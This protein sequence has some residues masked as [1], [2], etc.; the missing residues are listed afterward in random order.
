M[1]HLPAIFVLVLASCDAS[2][3]RSSQLEGEPSH[4]MAQS[5]AAVERMPEGESPAEIGPATTLQNE[6]SL[7]LNVANLPSKRVRLSGTTNLPSGTKLSLSVEEV[8]ENGFFGQSTCFV[9]SN[10]DFESEA[11]GPEGGLKDGRYVANATMP[12][13]SVQPTAV[14]KVIGNHG[15]NLTGSLVKKGSL[16]IIVSQQKEFAIGAMPEA[17]QAERKHRSDA[18][19][20]ALKRNLCVYLEQLLAFKNDRAFREY[21]FGIGGPYNKWL[22]G[23]E[24]LRAAQP[25]GSHSIPLVL[26]AA[27]GDLVTLGMDFMRKGETDYTRQ[28]LP[29]LKEAIGFDAYLAAKNTSLTTHEM[30][31]GTTPSTGASSTIAPANPISEEP[32]SAKERRERAEAKLNF[33]KKLLRTNVNAAKKRLEEIVKDFADTEAATEA[34][35]LLEVK[36]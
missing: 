25:K 35:K 32:Q 17:A 2:T 15:E 27:P 6:V 11:F 14:K 21:G 36:E 20:A 19:I 26:R 13:A 5:P 22:K 30:V 4:P 10:G 7:T 23:V 12:V 24:G 28:M 8:L 1:K 31:S 9:S 29:E 34:A 33:A 16:G 3:P 18:E